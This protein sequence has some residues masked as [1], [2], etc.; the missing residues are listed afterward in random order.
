MAHKPHKRPARVTSTIRRRFHTAQRWQHCLGLDRAH[1]TRA[2]DY[3]YRHSSSL[4]RPG[5][6]SQ[7]GSGPSLRTML[8]VA[9]SFLFTYA[10]ICFLS[11]GVRVSIRHTSPA[12]SL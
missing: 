5:A 2:Q 11:G 1:T 4:G 7:L 3:K 9:L 6:M 12:A 8:T 10:A